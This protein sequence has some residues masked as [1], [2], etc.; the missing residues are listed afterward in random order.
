MEFQNTVVGDGGMP[1]GIHDR[2]VII[3]IK[4]VR[5]RGT[6]TTVPYKVMR[7]IVVGEG[8]PLPFSFI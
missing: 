1:V 8:F 3:H 5:V 7:N 4:S 6:V 2:P